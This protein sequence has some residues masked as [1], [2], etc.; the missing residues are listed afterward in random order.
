[1]KAWLCWIFGHRYRL[2][3]DGQTYVYRCLRCPRVTKGPLRSSYQ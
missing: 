1:M 3:W 2:V